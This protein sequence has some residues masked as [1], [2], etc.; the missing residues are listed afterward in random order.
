VLLNSDDS[1]YGG[2]GMRA[3]IT[4]EAVPCHGMLYSALVNMP[5]LAVV[6]IAPVAE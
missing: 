6:F 3:D 5:P 2:S 4:V 1:Q